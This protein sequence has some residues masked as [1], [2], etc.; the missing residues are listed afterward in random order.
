MDVELYQ[1]TPNFGLDDHKKVLI[2]FAL[3]PKKKSLIKLELRL[4]I[5]YHALDLLITHNSKKEKIIII[6]QLEEVLFW[7]ET[8]S[9]SRRLVRVMISNRK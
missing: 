2:I 9:V 5:C 3:Y 6:S 8:P 1:E 4:M 7:L